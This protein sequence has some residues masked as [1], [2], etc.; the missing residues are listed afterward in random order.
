MLSNLL[1]VEEGIFES[2][3]DCSH[4]TES[5]TLQVLAL[6]ER[7]AVLEQTNIVACYRIP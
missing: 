6:K 3:G 5:G 1:E 7:L 2:L 4:T